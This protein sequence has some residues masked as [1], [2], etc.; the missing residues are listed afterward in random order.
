MTVAI[1][2]DMAAHPPRGESGVFM[3]READPNRCK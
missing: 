3:C 1:N 2:S